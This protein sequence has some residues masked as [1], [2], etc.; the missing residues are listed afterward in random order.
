MSQANDLW[1]VRLPDGQ[2]V[3]ANSTDAVRHHLVTGR[4]PR[5]S[6]VR[7][8]PDEEWVSVEWAPELGGLG[9]LGGLG[10]SPIADAPRKRT[11]PGKREP[12]SL[13]APEVVS[14]EDTLTPPSP[15]RGRSRQDR[16]QLQVVGARGMFEEL[17]KAVD[18][19]LE[20]IKLRVACVTALACVLLVTLVGLI[21]LDLEWPVL[22]LPWGAAALGVL[23]FGAIGIALITQTSFV[24]LSTAKPARSRDSTRALPRNALRLF[25]GF[26]VVIGGPLILLVGIYLLVGWLPTS[27]IEPSAHAAIAGVSLLLSILIFVLLGPVLAFAHLLG[28][29]VVIEEAS[30]GRSLGQWWQLV[31]QHFGR[32]YFYEACAAAIGTVA[33]LPMLLPALWLTQALGTEP[34]SGPWGTL[35][36]VLLAILRGVALT[37]LLAYLTV[38]NVFI[39]LNLRYET[40][41]KK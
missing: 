20:R 18:S 11:E 35:A 28:P 19:T 6:W 38:A 12:A 36:A 37:P 15:G 34:A 17:L 8:S 9:G 22:L 32:L 10:S 26:L 5:D 2:I 24:E 21:R 14:H 41:P 4:I 1:Y 30:A 33:S 25:C 3:R 39:Y 29:V 7:R 27:D 13:E 40:G 31:R 23:M 16:L